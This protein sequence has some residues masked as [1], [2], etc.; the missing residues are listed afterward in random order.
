MQRKSILSDS[1][2]L[3]DFLLG[4]IFQLHDQVQVKFLGNI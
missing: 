3:E 1:L 4:L 2:G